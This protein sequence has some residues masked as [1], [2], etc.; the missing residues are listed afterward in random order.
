MS[1]KQV[2]TIPI[3]LNLEGFEREAIVDMCR[4]A[5]SLINAAR[6]LVRQH[7][8]NSGKPA[9]VTCEYESLDLEMK[10]QGNLNYKA[11]YSQAAQRILRSVAAEFASFNGLM[12]RFFSGE[13]DRP[14]LPGYRTK[15][16]LAPVIYPAQNLEFDLESGMVKLPLGK[17]VKAEVAGMLDELWIPGCVGIKPSQLIEVRILPRNGEFY[18]EYVYRS[19]AFVADV[20]PLRA[21]GIDPGV[22]NWLTCV[23]N[24]G[25]SFILDGRRLKS[26]NQYY[27]KQVAKLKEGKPQGYW[28]ECLASITEKRN[29]QMRDAINKAARFILNWCLKHQVG[30][31]VFGWNIQIKD[32]INIGAK[33]NQQFVQ[34][35]TARLKA[36]LA[37]LCEQYGIRFVETEEA[38]TSVASFLDGDSLPKHGEKPEGWKASGKRVKRGLYRTAK[39]HLISADANGGANILRKVATQ[40]GI[41]LAEVGRAVLTLPQRYDIFSNLKKSY[42]EKSEEA[43]LQ[44]AS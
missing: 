8:F 6:Y 36:R 35:P 30:T 1:Q 27:N 28:D 7:Y 15:G 37:Q 10:L 18:A 23:S 20:D 16:G 13:G 2:G 31:V 44:P 29:R 32:G 38:N 19:K 11:L 4:E 14:K 5:N 34:I 21:L 42:R 33:N 39:R 43:R 25:R 26:L 12:E 9:F 17:Q 40:L 41:S 22:N 24:V 3:R